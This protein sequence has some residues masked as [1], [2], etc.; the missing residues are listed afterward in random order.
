MLSPFVP[1][2]VYARSGPV[3]DSV[4]LSNQDQ[5]QDTCSVTTMLKELGWPSP[6]V[7]EEGQTRLTIIT[8]SREFI[9]RFQ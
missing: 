4:S 5:D 1:V 9:E 2:D 8:N 3:T 7:K 6:A